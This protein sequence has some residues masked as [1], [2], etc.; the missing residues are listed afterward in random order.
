[1][2]NKICPRC[3]QEMILMGLSVGS[4]SMHKWV[5]T[6]CCYMVDYQSVEASQLKEA[7]QNGQTQGTV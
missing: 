3:Q 4:I 5:C 7:E 2:G 6:N 1:M